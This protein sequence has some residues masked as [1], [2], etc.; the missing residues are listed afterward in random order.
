MKDLLLVAVVLLAVT[1]LTGLINQHNKILKLREEIVV[2][3][4]DTAGC[5]EHIAKLTSKKEKHK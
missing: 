3:E 1:C 2:L 5:Y 4:R